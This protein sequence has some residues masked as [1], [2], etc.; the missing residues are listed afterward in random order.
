M[1]IC[2]K[3]LFFVWIFVKTSSQGSGIRKILW[4]VKFTLQK[5]Q[6]SNSASL[7]KYLQRI[8]TKI[9]CCYWWWSFLRRDIIKY[10]IRQA[11][12]IVMTMQFL[13]TVFYFIW[14]KGG[15]AIKCLHCY[16]TFRSKCKIL[17]I[18]N[19]RAF[20]FSLKFN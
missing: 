9:L 1:D 16:V 14:L 4:F 8:C 13:L 6:T 2:W 12:W 18:L 15:V 3:Y 11:I 7:S 20:L 19:F 10:V 5:N 17:D